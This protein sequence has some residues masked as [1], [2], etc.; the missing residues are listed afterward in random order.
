M[1]LSQIVASVP[2]V[3]P[4]PADYVTTITTAFSGFLPALLLV[5]AAGLGIGV[6]KW[7]F[8]VVVGFFKKT[9]K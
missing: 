2:M 9:A 8:P 3:D 1:S 4:T 7:G 6:L 5:A